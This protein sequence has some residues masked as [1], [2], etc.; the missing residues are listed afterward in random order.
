M[1]STD[2]QAVSV[3]LVP[4][5][6]AGAWMWREVAEQLE[7]AGI[8]ALVLELPTYGSDAQDR[9]FADD[10]SAVTEALDGVESV[11]LAAHS[12]GGAVITAAAAGP[13][14]SVRELVYV[15]AAAPG[16]GES[17]AGVSAAAAAAAGQ[18]EDSPGP[19]PREDG[20][21]VFAPEVARQA[22][23]N[24]CSD[25]RARE[26]LALLS[27]QSLAGTD[28]VIPVAAWTQLPS[29]YVRGV[30]DLVPRAIT[31]GFLDS[32]EEV[33]DVPTGHCPQWSRPELITDVLRTR[34]TG[35]RGGAA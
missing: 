18:G 5:A 9:T 35:V 33:I 29:V 25:E 27:P 22:L 34:V 6:F 23:F 12:Y 32:C 15:A 1:S 16:S 31:D 3:V 4:G 14:P 10:V 17:M 20:L 28:Q 13:H 8:E 30:D 21:L 24:D 19:A 2:K 11:V 7:R 26:G